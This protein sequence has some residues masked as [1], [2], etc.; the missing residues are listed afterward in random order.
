MQNTGQTDEEFS[1]DIPENP[2]HC[3]CYKIII[4]DMGIPIA[5]KWLNIQADANNRK[6]GGRHETIRHP[7]DLH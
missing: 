4:A 2:V 1:P 6:G 3:G 5:W 7:G